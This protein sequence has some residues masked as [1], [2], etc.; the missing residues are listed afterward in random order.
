VFLC[1]LIRN[2]LLTR[3]VEVAGCCGW[4]TICNGLPGFY[5]DRAC[6]SPV[7]G[8]MWLYW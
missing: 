5:R 6:I 7:C 3:R 4:L 2:F 8:G 1:V